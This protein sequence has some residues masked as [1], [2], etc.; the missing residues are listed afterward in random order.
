MT[1]DDAKTIESYLRTIVGDGS[2]EWVY[3]PI[4]T[5]ILRDAAD[6]IAMLPRDESRASITDELRS[7][8]DANRSCEGRQNA[9]SEQAAEQLLA[10]ADNIDILHASRMEQSSRAIRKASCRYMRS[11]IN[12]YER[13][14]KRVRKHHATRKD[15]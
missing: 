13:G 14:C 1:M 11:V 4:Q 10:I 15:G 2:V 7:W 9:I 3:Q 8:I 6:L 5:F 12:D